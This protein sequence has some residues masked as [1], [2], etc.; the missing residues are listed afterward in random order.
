MDK[1]KVRE[2]KL[3][4]ILDASKRAEEILED[5]WKDLYLDAEEHRKIFNLKE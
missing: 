2:E 5:I 3:Q 4:K 1:K